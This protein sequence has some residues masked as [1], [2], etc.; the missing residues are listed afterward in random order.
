MQIIHEDNLSSGLQGAYAERTILHRRI[1][2][3]SFARQ[4]QRRPIDRH[5]LQKGSGR[6]EKQISGDSLAEVENT[7]V[8]AGRFADEH[9]FEHLLDG[10]RRARIADEIGP[11]IA[12]SDFAERHVVAHY[13]DLFAILDDLGEFVV[14]K[15]RFDRLV[16]LDI[17]QFGAADDAFL[18]LSR[19]RVPGSQIMKIL[20]HDDIAAASEAGVL[21]ADENG[22]E[23]G[24]TIRVLRAVDKA[25]QITLVEKAEA[26]NLVGRRNV[27]A[28]LAHDLACEFETQIHTL[29]AD[30]K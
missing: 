15:A 30:M 1:G 26:V 9:I 2:S 21:V 17:G 11:E 22:I 25:E 14:G 7:V 8:V 23:R 10:A 6:R 5:I 4:R 20:L 18:R 24:L 28:D 27:V 16:E 12:L 19:Q 3:G 13:F 29:A